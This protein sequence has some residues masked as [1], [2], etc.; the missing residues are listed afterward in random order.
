MK[1]VR[2]RFAIGLL[3]GLLVF[4]GVRTV[5]AGPIQ[6]LLSQGKVEDAKKLLKEKPR[7][8]NSIDPR[9]QTPLYIAAK[10]RQTDAVELLIKLGANLNQPSNDRDWGVRLTPLRVAV[11][12][13][14][15]MAA[16]P[17]R[18]KMGDE[19]NKIIKLLLAASADCDLIS[20]CYLGDFKQVQ[21]ILAADPK[22]VIDR[23]AISAAAS[24][25]HADIIELFLEHGVSPG[26][27]FCKGIR[28]C[29]W[30][31]NASAADHPEVLKLLFD[32]GA[33]PKVNVFDRGRGVLSDATL[34]HLVARGK[35]ERNALN[36]FELRSQSNP[37]TRK[38]CL[39]S[40]EL[41]LQRGV[42]RD[43]K[44]RNG[45]TP[46]HVASYC[47]FPEMVE[48]LLDNGADPSIK[49]DQGQTPRQLAA[50]KLHPNAE[51]ACKASNDALRKVI[52]VLKKPR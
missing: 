39:E 3:L 23:K 22:M 11:Q 50:S 47:G 12:R 31:I 10:L 4:A 25:G 7:L 5:S 13:H 8:A 19:Y 26:D 29:S 51:P 43:V 1:L 17:G 48:F 14:A 45:Y 6:D 49:N 41:P 28:N 24:G 42:P 46:L 35:T 20:A 36:V 38:R 16:T 15:W 2:N 30:T 33:D 18:Q 52:E 27:D 9:G 44:N 37:A 32:A 34:L 40:A 21:T